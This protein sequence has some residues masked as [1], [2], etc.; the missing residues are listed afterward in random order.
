M[1]AIEFPGYNTL[2]TRPT[3][4]TDEECSSIVAYR[5]IDADSHP[6]ILT[7]WQTSK[8]PAMQYLGTIWKNYVNPMEKLDCGMCLER[9]LNNYRQLQPV[10]I[11]MEKERKLLG[12]V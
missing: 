6:F 11:E 4:M 2:L 9:V 5:G 3:N 7:V 1:M 12:S 8:D 10:M